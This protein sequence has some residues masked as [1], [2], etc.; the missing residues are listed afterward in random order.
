METVYKGYDNRFARRLR[1]NGKIVSQEDFNSI[2]Q[3]GIVFNNVLYTSNQYDTAFDL[4]SRATERIIV[5]SLGKI[6]ALPVSRDKNA[7]V[8][9]YTTV[10]PSGIVWGSLDIN[11]VSLGV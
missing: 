7:L 2:T 10:F 5:F 4:I 1:S 9:I 8:V 6:A 3:V 11:V